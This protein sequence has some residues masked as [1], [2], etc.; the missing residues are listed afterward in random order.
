MPGPDN[1]PVILQGGHADVLREALKDHIQT[2]SQGLS[3]HLESGDVRDARDYAHRVVSATAA[4]DAIGWEPPAKR[5][6]F[7]S[8]DQ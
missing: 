5:D 8:G 4:L 6:R 3:G 7:Q 1:S 2:F